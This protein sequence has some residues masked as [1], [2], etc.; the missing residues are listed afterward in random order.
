MF[1]LDEPT[2]G[3]SFRDTN[4]LMLLLNDIV[5]TGNS[6]ILIEHDT[7]VLKSCDCGILIGKIGR[8]N[9]ALAVYNQDNRLVFC[10]CIAAV[11]AP[12]KR[13]RD[14]AITATINDL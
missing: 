4:H 1:I 5:D 14:M 7:G 8:E 12:A 13:I 6:M 11:Y 10:S 9:Y 2:T 3:L